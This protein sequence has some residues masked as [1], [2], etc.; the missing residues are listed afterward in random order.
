[1]A[2]VWG[3]VMVQLKRHVETGVAGP[4]FV[5][6]SDRS[7]SLPPLTSLDRVRWWPPLARRTLR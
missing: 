1:M 2:Y 7:T 5:H 6:S 3:Q 4:V